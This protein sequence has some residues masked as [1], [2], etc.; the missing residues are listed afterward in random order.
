MSKRNAGTVG[1]IGPA[2]GAAARAGGEGASAP[3][4]WRM[5]AA[6]AAGPRAPRDRP[7]DTT[8]GGICVKQLRPFVIPYFISTIKAVVARDFVAAGPV[9]RGKGCGQ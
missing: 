5:A 2:V 6:A 3:A 8:S 1:G 4:A 7:W 9:R